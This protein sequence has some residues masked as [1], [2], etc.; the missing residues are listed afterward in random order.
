METVGCNEIQQQDLFGVYLMPNGE[1]LKELKKLAD[2]DEISIKAA[3]R[4]IL[5][6]Q[7]TVHN[8]IGS[9]IDFQ[10]G[11]NKSLDSYIKKR[12]ENANS[13]KKA[14]ENLTKINLKEHTEIKE[15]VESTRTCIREG[16]KEI[17]ENPSIVVGT[18]IKKYPKITYFLGA[19]SLIVVNLWFIPEFR[20]I[21]LGWLKIAIP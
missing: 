15:E 2:E 11:L 10:K 19:V 20:N 16:L 4:L 18:F 7:V 1:M 12:D 13:Q 17:K 5:T 21:V 14:I 9:I 6:S 3:I 8:D